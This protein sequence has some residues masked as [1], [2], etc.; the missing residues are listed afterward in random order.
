[1]EIVDDSI[2]ELYEKEI[3]KPFN[4]AL[5][6]EFETENKQPEIKKKVINEQIINQDTI[7]EIAD[8]DDDSIDDVIAE[9]IKRRRYTTEWDDVYKIFV[10]MGV[11]NNPYLAYKIR[12]ISK[13]LTNLAIQVE[14]SQMAQEDEKEKGLNE[15]LAQRRK[16]I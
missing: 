4:D 14:K 13:E 3:I 6:K 9:V 16:R 7:G 15:R 12:R 5:K 11:D 10:E 8:E 1:M 2:V